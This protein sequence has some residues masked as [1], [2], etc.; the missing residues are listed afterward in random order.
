MPYPELERSLCLPNG[1]RHVV[2]DGGMT[3]F[4]PEEWGLPPFAPDGV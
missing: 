2:V 1:E 3:A 4:K